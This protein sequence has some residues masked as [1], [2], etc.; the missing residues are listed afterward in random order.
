MQ[1]DERSEKNL[2][3]VHADLVKVVRKAAELA[4]ADGLEFRITE[5]LRTLARQRQLLAA[6]ASS[7]MKS[8]HLDGHAV[9]FVPVVSG[10]ISWK[11]PAFWPL[12]EVFERAAKEVGIPV[13]MGA[14]WRKFADGPHVQLPWKDYPLTTGA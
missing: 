10:E 4:K 8:R 6:G 7:T 14:R 9:D 5:G 12:V 2:T 1:I 13:E 11:W 3:G